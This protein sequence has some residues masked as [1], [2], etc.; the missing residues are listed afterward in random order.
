M[1]KNMKISRIALV[2]TLLA[3]A[4]C[5]KEEDPKPSLKTLDG[6]LS[7]EALPEYVNPGMT[8]DYDASAVSIPEEESD[9]SLVLSYV[10][11]LTVDSESVSDTLSVPNYTLVVPDKLGKM[12]LKCTVTALG[13]YS[14]TASVN[15]T[16]LSDKSIVYEKPSGE[17]SFTEDD[18]VFYAVENNDLLWMSRN[19]S[20]G[21]TPYY[22]EPAALGIYGGY[23]TWNDALSACPDGWT[24]PTLE[25]WDAL[26][27]KSGDLMCNVTLNGS[28][29]WEFWPE[30]VITN[31]TGISAIPVGY[32]ERRDDH[33]NFAGFNEYAVF[34]ASDGGKAACRYIF[35]SDPDV[36]TFSTIDEDNFY[37]SL[38]CVKAVE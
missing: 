7:F 9:K 12:T 15:A 35:V 28:R 8:F 18:T 1:K 27:T 38:R 32:A 3:L 5:K 17:Q 14:V 34:W 16:I 11:N 29:M 21:G 23:Y 36:K 25:Q 2:L 31:S 22:R 13:Y 19:Y 4:A 33:F 24:I 30:V 6:S 37:A 10:F 20:K 26:S